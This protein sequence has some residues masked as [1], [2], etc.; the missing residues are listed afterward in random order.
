MFLI[1]GLSGQHFY[2]CR[3]S[4][5]RWDNWTALKD[6]LVNAVSKAV[7]YAFVSPV[8]TVA[9]VAAT[10]FVIIGLWGIAEEATQHRSQFNKNMG[11]KIAAAARRR[12]EQ[13]RI[14][15]VS[16]TIPY[17]S[18]GIGLPLPYAEYDATMWLQYFRNRNVNFAYSGKAVGFQSGGA[19]GIPVY[20]LLETLHRGKVSGIRMDSVGYFEIDVA[21]LPVANVAE[22]KLGPDSSLS[23]L[24][25]LGTTLVER[26]VAGNSVSMVAVKCNSPVALRAG[27]EGTSGERPTFTSPCIRAGREGKA[28]LY[29]QYAI[30]RSL[31]DGALVKMDKMDKFARG[32][33][34]LRLIELAPQVTEPLL[35]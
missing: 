9:L 30:F 10:A 1:A 20:H 15:S 33:S 28:Y 14:A 12:G 3:R 21:K 5:L 11:K 19:Y 13:P 17:Y 6:F 25:E 7:R 32:P 23:V 35:P 18:G 2:N 4:T 26:L 27:G 24:R 34:R 29:V 16:L 31:P 8:K 22:A